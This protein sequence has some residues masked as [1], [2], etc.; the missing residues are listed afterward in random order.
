MAVTASIVVNFGGTTAGSSLKAE[1]D[2]RDEVSGGLNAGKTSFLAGDR[3]G[4]LVFKNRVTN[5]T[6]TSSAGSISTGPTG[7]KVF[8]EDV[9]FVNSNEANLSYTATAIS[10][11]T[12]LGNSLGNVVNAGDGK[13]RSAQKGV[14]IARIT[15]TAQYSSYYLQSPATLGGLTNFPIVVFITGEEQL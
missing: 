8:T 15:Y 9:E 5:V 3:V 12:W 2:N 14:A 1:V 4:I 6:A 11:V 10:N 13:V 7:L